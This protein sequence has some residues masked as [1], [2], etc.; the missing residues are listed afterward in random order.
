M[1][2]HPM[3]NYI[4]FTEHH[5]NSIN[6]AGFTTARFS[7][8]YSKLL[9]SHGW[10]SL[11]VTHSNGYGTWQPPIGL[12]EVD[13]VLAAQKDDAE[14]I[15]R[16]KLRDN[17]GRR[18][19]RISRNIHN[20]GLRRGGVNQKVFEKFASILTGISLSTGDNHV[21]GGGWTGVAVEAAVQIS[22]LV[23]VDAAVS[24]NCWAP[25]FA[26]NRFSKAT[27]IPW[28]LNFTDP[29]QASV[30][31]EGRILLGWYLDHF[32]FRSA[33]AVTQC[34]PYW[35][36]ELSGELRRPVS[37]LINAYDEDRMHAAQPRTFNR[38]TIVATGAIE[39]PSYNPE[40][41]L[42]GLA[43]LKAHQLNLAEKLQF[44]YIGPEGDVLQKRAMAHGVADLVRCIGPLSHEEVIPYTKGAQLSLVT[45]DQDPPLNVG[46]L[47]AKTPE[48]LG[49][50]R[51]ILLIAKTRGRQDTDLV[52]LIRDTGSGW[53]V[54]DPKEV[55][56]VIGQL[57]EKYLREGQINR[58]G[59]GKFPVGDF[60]Y[61]GQASKLSQILER[62]AS[63]ER[64]PQVEDIRQAYP[65]SLIAQS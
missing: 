59:A 53:A 39:S 36:Y 21:T 58:P 48:Y 56:A 16:L 33:A 31:P 42:S 45:L 13:R 34:T 4:L 5:D 22:K 35:A 38:F 19:I 47:L 14:V 41:F 15:F 18:L 3:R 40:V 11:V 64:D 65:W 10:R 20:I 62:V 46:R 24:F 49:S 25:P 28:I 26:A 6:T 30:S 57:L 2:G 54:W 1:A 52:R 51:P 23:K 29:W 9:S 61:Q 12:D 32:I 17:F 43:L 37:C 60:T 27:G 7:K 55:A 50:N 63:G 44:V 8:Y